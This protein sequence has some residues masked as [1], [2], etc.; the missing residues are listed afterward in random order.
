MPSLGAGCRA[1]GKPLPA[2]GESTMIGKLSIDVVD[3][4]LKSDGTG[5]LKCS[6]ALDGIYTLELDGRSVYITTADDPPGAGVGVINMAGASFATH[7][8][9]W[10]PKF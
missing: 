5:T 3:V 1:F 9:A 10:K 8:F 2:A 6:H 4:D 7:R